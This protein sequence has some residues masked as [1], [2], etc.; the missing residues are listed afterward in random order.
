MS[1]HDRLGK[2]AAQPWHRAYLAK[3]YKA[4]WELVVETGENPLDGLQRPRVLLC[5]SGSAETTATC[6][7]AV[8]RV[9]PDAALVVIDSSNAPL[10]ASAAQTKAEYLQADARALPFADGSFHW[11]ETDFFLQYFDEAGKRAL[12]AECIHDGIFTRRLIR[13]DII[14]RLTD[15]LIKI[16]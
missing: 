13:K 4:S 5:G 14:F 6:A 10:R 11:I 12:F 9:A 7:E 1:L 8:R 15:Q 2:Y 3:A 16:F